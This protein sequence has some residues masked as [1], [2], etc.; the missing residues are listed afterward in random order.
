MTGES[1]CEIGSPDHAVDLRGLIDHLDA[2]DVAQFAGQNLP[3]SGLFA[4]GSRAEGEYAAGPHAQH[5]AD[6]PL[7]THAQA[8]H[9]VLGGVL[10]Q[11]PHHHDVVVQ[12]GC[13]GDQLVKVRRILVHVGELPIYV[14]GSLEVMVRNDEPDPV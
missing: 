13:G 1:E 11:E 8:D 6:N 4:L 14:L 9:L 3:G 5:A 12:A 10:F 2:V 7:L